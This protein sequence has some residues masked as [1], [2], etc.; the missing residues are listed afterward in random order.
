MVRYIIEWNRVSICHCGVVNILEIIL[1]NVASLC[2]GLSCA[3][4]KINLVTGFFKT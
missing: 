2:F 4:V 3:S 1:D